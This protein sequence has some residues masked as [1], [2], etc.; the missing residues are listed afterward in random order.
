MDSIIV[1]GI[2]FAYSFA[3]GI[4][5]SMIAEDK[6]RGQFIWFVN[7]FLFNVIAIIA[8]GFLPSKAIKL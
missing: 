8:I 7:G 5:C 3:S 4:F 2:A 6:Y 1:I